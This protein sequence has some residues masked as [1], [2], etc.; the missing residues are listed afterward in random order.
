[1]NAHRDRIIELDQTGNQ[2]KF[3]SQKQDVVLIKNLL[4]SVQSRWEKVV[5]RSVERGRA[6]DDARKRAKQVRNV[7]RVRQ[8]PRYGQPW[9]GGGPKTGRGLGTA[10]VLSF[11]L[12]PV[13]LQ[14]HEAWKKLIDWLE[15]AE[16][17]LD[18]EL[19]ISNDPDKIKLQLSKHKV[20]LCQ[21]KTGA[22][23]WVEG[24]FVGRGSRATSPL[25]SGQGRS[26][27]MPTA[28]MENTQLGIFTSTTYLQRAK[29]RLS[30]AVLFSLRFSGVP[31]DTGGE[32][33]CL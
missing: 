17:H 16:N 8:T 30:E 13:S 6:L 15:D 31:E 1:M 23:R 3:L 4:V 12:A 28:A 11:R 10:P 26:M 29:A 7:G 5:Q 21:S 22:G 2:L 25:P 14:F 33:A 20:E 9:S 19:E 18:S 24:C 32:A 27:S